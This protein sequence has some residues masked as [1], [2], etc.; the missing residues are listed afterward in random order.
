MEKIDQDQLLADLHIMPACAGPRDSD[1]NVDIIVDSCSRKCMAIARRSLGYLVRLCACIDLYAKVHSKHADSRHGVL[2][3]SI[4]HES[5][6]VSLCCCTHEAM[7]NEMCLQKTRLKIRK[8]QT[9]RWLISASCSN[10]VPARSNVVFCSQAIDDG[11]LDTAQ[12]THG[13][14]P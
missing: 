2:H 13:M 4:G 5:G 7:G 3:T 11:S 8:Q 10:R 12:S 9:R 1:K 6:Q 14:L